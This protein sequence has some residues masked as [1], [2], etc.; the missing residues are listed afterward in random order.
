MEILGLIQRTELFQGLSTN[1]LA[2]I[3]AI[4][5]R[6]SFSEGEYFAREKD[7][8]DRLAIVKEGMMEIVVSPGGDLP[9][10]TVVHLGRGQI[11]GEMTLVDGGTRSATVRVMRTPT[12][13][14]TLQHKPFHDLCEANPNIGYVVMKNIASDLSFKLRHRSLEFRGE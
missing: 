3:A 11:V 1:E 14:V 7:P 6:E 10:K 9:E 12:E 13:V 8:A 5:E 4:C 2:E